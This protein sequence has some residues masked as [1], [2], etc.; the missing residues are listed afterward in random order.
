MNDCLSLEEVKAY[1]EC[2][3]YQ[4]LMKVFKHDS[5]SAI[6]FKCQKEGQA[7]HFIKE[8]INLCFDTK[9]LVLCHACH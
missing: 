2:R 1:Q 5:N 4:K 9:L 3:S 7:I 8:S 6:C